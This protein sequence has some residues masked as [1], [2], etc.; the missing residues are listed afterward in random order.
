MESY[1]KP[2]ALSFGSRP[3]STARFDIPPDNYLIISV[4]KFQ[5]PV[6]ISEALYMLDKLAKV[7]FLSLP[8]AEKRERLLGDFE[9]LRSRPT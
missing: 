7:K 1:F 9:W 3:R 5:N 4:S 6:F 2:L 8:F